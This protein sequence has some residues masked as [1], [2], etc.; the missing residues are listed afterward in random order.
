MSISAFQSVVQEMT[1]FRKL[2]H[3][4][5]ELAG[6]EKWTCSEIRRRLAE[7][8]GVEVL[9]PFLETDTV[10][11][12]HGKAPGKNV[13]LRADIDALTVT[14]ETG[15]DFASENPG[16]MHACGHDVHTAVLMGAAKMLAAK[17]NEF[18]GSIRLVFQPGEENKAM[19]RPLIAAGALDDPPADFVAALHCMP[20]LEVGK[21]RLRIGAMMSSCVHFE[22]SFYGVGG[23]GS[24]PHAARNPL[25]AACSAVMELQTAIPNRINSQR[26]GVLSI[27]AI[28]GGKLDNVIP[29][30]CSFIGTIRALDDETAAELRTALVD[31]CQ[32]IGTLHRCKCDVH[33]AEGGYPAT[34]NSESGFALA[35]QTLENCNIGVEVMP[36]S[37]MASEDFSYY[38]NK[39]SDG[40]FIMMGAGEDQ[41]PLHNCRFLADEKMIGHGI[42][43]MTEIALAAL[44]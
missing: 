5:P 28:N 13:T 25:I 18:S 15:C 4:H 22:V 27:C 19:A 41:L 14:E 16:L 10:A 33:L 31:M 34:I 38:L 37:F 17:R 29:E 9:P 11:F 8:P 36:E 43:Y 7:I 23:H 21:A 30:K 2:L 6:C 42:A 12:I 20:G 3:R 24:R 39:A 35:K 40:V 1:E 44:K 32:A 26:A